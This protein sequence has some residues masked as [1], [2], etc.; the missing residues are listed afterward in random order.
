MSQLEEMKPGVMYQTGVAVKAAKKSVKKSA[1]PRNPKGT[2]LKNWKCPYYHKDFCFST[3]HKDCRSPDCFMRGKTKD[4]RDAAVKE[5]ETRVIAI[6]VEKL[7]SEG[8]T[9]RWS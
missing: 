3:G 2:L 9:C 4:V 1:V 8:K 5:I 7:A 6:E